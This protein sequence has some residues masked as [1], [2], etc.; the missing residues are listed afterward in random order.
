MAGRFEPKTPV[1]LNPPKDDPISAEELAQADGRCPHIPPYLSHTVR[2]QVI[3]WAHGT[4]TMSAL[5]L[6]TIYRPSTSLFLESL[7]MSQ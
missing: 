5:A 1:Q 2:L 6:F 7:L 3:I 4:S